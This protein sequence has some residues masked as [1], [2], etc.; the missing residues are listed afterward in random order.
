[1]GAGEKAIFEPKRVALVGASESKGAPEYAILFQRILQN[2][3]KFKKFYPIDIAGKISGC[4]KRIDKIPKGCDLVGVVLPEQLLLKNFRKI[5]SRAR[6]IVIFTREI[7]PKLDMEFKK[8]KKVRV[9]G[10]ASIGVINQKANLA[11]TYKQPPSEG[12]IALVSQREEISSEILE[13]FRENGVGVGKVLCIGDSTNLSWALEYLAND[14]KTSVVCLHVQNKVSGRELIEALHLFGS[15]KPVIVFK[16]DFVDPVFRS[17]VRQSKGIFAQDLEAFV[18]VAKVLSQKSVPLGKNVAV[19]ANSKALCKVALKLLKEKEFSLVKPSEKILKSISKKVPSVV[20]EGD[21]LLPFSVDLGEF[22]TVAETLSEDENLDF[23]VC[24]FRV[25]YSTNPEKVDQFITK[26][27]KI[28]K[29]TFLCVTVPEEL[30]PKIKSLSQVF[31]NLKMC[32]AGLGVASEIPIVK[33]DQ[34]AR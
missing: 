17:A 13:E 11:L 16:S 10:P 34:R 19:L 28:K 33:E 26:I 5:I 12:S 3:S 29:P 18:A 24:V 30:R 14:K 15:E 23:L 27:M 21:I 20:G 4:E 1:M 6:S 2:M 22:K 31:T 9:I 32:I 8:V 25:L 7:S